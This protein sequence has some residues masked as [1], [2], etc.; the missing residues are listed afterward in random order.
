M[1]EIITGLPFTA[2]LIV[3]DEVRTVFVDS[4]IRQMHVNIFLKNDHKSVCL[5][6]DKEKYLL[7]GNCKSNYGNLGTRLINSF[8]C[9]KD[10][11]VSSCKTQLEFPICNIF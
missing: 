9:R 8:I 3:P 4:V 5:V 6:V 7:S 11:F 1:R 10:I 2:C